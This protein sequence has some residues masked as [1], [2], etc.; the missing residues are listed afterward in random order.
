MINSKNMKNLIIK[1]LVILILPLSGEITF[2]QNPIDPGD[3]PNN[4]DIPGFYKSRL[5]DIKAEIAGLKI[6]K[7][8][9]IASTPGGLPLYAVYYGQK[10]DF[11]SQANYNSALGAGNAAYYAKKDSCTKP[12]VYFV[13]PVH[14]SEGKE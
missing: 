7:A 6:G 1:Y 2:S 8:E 11:Q 3:P 5:S 4:K 10:D 13:G 12:V 14:G 9:V